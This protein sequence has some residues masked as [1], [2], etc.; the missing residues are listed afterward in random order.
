MRQ[1]VRWLAGGLLALASGAAMALGLGEIRV[2][3]QPG[4]P[5]LAEIPIVSSDPA[6][7]EQLQARL[8]SPATFERVGLERPRGLV[9]ELNFAV[10]LSDQGQPVIRVTSAAPVEQA[11][12]NFLIEV[13]WG[14]GRLVREYSALVSTPEAMAAVA[15]PAVE[16]PLPAPS[17]AIV[18]EPQVAAPVETETPAPAEPQPTAAAPPSAPVPIPAPIPVPA[19]P[20]P[21]AS[22][23]APVATAAGPG[24]ALAPVRRGQTLSGI[25]SRLNTGY[26]LDQTML[27]L[28]R[29]NPE[30]FIGGNIN[31]LKQGAVL[32]VP[33][34]SELAQLDRAEASALVRQ[35]VAE[36]RQAR[37]PVV[38]P[39]AVAATTASASPAG[40]GGPIDQARLEIAPPAAAVTD[41]AGTT[42]GIQ[43][44]GEGDMLAEQQLQQAREDVAARE[45]EVQ[46]LRAQVAELEKIKQQQEQLIAMKD[47]DLA[48]AQQRLSQTQG[49]EGVPTWLVA[50]LGLIIIGLLAGLLTSRRRAQAA[51][52]RPAPRPAGTFAVNAPV[53]GEDTDAPTPTGH[54]PFFGGGGA[55]EEVPAVASDAEWE[56]AHLAKPTWHTG[57]DALDVSPLGIGDA[58]EGHDRLELAI[59]YLDLGD[60]ETARDLLNEVLAGDDEPARQEAA[61]LLRELE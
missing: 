36:W 5:L 40:T 48:A 38:Q 8:A 24:D 1:L 49:G 28:L 59:A 44:G 37:R 19:A 46:E 34:T 23:P 29:A 60:T 27:A 16:A 30:A 42:S 35:Q 33:Q 57:D 55:A 10:A 25:A 15:A 20:P 58:P 45:S 13:D 53:R 39:A 11:A 43:A 3:S 31:R 50:G 17:N 6:E 2:L 54:D 51:A 21:E 32:R 14:Q 26:S 61:R 41:R 56:Q 12:V 18:R 22:P 47:S 7:M 52:A 4:Q 9:S